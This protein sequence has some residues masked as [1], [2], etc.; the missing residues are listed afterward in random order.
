MQQADYPAQPAPDTGQGRARDVPVS[1][2]T[3]GDSRSFTEQPSTLLACATAGPLT[4]ASSFAS[5]GSGVR[6]PLAPPRSGPITILKSHL[7]GPIQREST[8]PAQ[9]WRDRA[10]N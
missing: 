5:R 8:A 9:L 2:A 7:V 4:A 6:V 1:K 10:L 3:H